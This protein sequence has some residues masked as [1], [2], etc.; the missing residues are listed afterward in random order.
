MVAT[1]GGTLL[2]CLSKT[3]MTVTL[4]STEAYYVALSACA[5]EIKFVSILLGEMAKVENPYVIHE[6]SR[7][8]IFLAK[9]RQVGIHTKH[10]GISHH[11]LQ[12]M[13]EEKD[14]DI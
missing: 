1:L 5:Q 12:K 6:N 8:N 9:N 14:I 10:I 3:Q 11:F 13:V 7:G 4:S 2:T